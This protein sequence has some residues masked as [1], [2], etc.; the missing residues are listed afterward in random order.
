MHLALVKDDGVTALAPHQG[1]LR[2]LLRS[3]AGDPESDLFGRLRAA[4][5]TGRTL[6][7][8]GFLAAIERLTG[9]PQTEQARSK[10][11]NTAKPFMQPVADCE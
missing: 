1:A 6:G 5:S 2:P 11:S 3:F 9:R 8:D 7:D 10:A 4:E